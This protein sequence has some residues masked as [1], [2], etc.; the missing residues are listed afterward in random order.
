[1]KHAPLYERLRQPDFHR[2]R[3]QRS[4]CLLLDQG[5]IDICR[6][7]QPWALPEHPSWDEDPY[8]DDTWGLYYH[9]LGWLISLDYGIDH[10]ADTGKRKSCES[11]LQE[12]FF[13][14]LRYLVGT[15]DTDVHKMLWFDH[16][17]AWRASVIAYLYE[18]RF[19]HRSAPDEIELLRSAALL[20]ERKLLEF[21]ESGRWKANNHG[22]FHAEALW[23]LA[24]TFDDALDP[25]AT[26]EVAL[27]AMR[28][29][30]AEMI[31]FKE[32]VCREHSI[33][34]H[35]YD[36]WLLS[37]SV[38]YMKR[39]GVDVVPD[40]RQ[41]L[42]KM[43]EFYHR[44][45]PGQRR[46]PAIGDTSFG[47]AST[48]SMLADIGALADLTPVARYLTD[49]GERVDRPQHLSTYPETGFY[50][51]HDESGAHGPTKASLAIVLDKPYMGAH[52]HTDG[53]SF[54]IDIEGRPV[55]VDS[56]GPFA[57]GKKLRFNYFKAAEAHNV[58]IVDRK[59]TSY[60][61]NASAHASSPYGAAVRLSA[62]NLV[63]GVDWQR[64]FVDLGFG[65][66]VV[67]DAITAEATRRFDA[68]LHFAPDL[69]VVPCGEGLHALQANGF[70]ASVTQVSNRA[71]DSAVV[72]GADQSFP[73]GMVTPDLGRQQ[74]APVLSTGFRASGGWLVTMINQGAPLD[75]AV[76]QL[77]GAKLLR[78]LIATEIGN[79]SIDVDLSKKELPP[80]LISYR[81]F[82]A[83][84]RRTSRTS[85]QEA[86][87]EN[88]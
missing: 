87:P 75:I 42:T 5:V 46:L 68:L 23:D 55:V 9:T 8:G 14:Y 16:S 59:S 24:H 22:I 71:I 45:A 31:N 48:S 56:G 86:T 32:G 80:R 67:V 74:P 84:S 61:T 76:H 58:V 38:E 52:A 1:M 50:V 15:P 33:Y 65:T 83:G 12:L 26:K 53:G 28:S 6:P 62:S 85:K 39:F 30:F 3:T 21:I 7:F 11:R 43:V 36:A 13:S 4:L 17:T 20:H 25:V 40:S 29:V 37:K 78:I 66:Y 73:R 64:S 44:C 72:I 81:A 57:Y 34:Y 77:F 69:E 18:R 88:E 35:L 49:V 19:K 10:G 2:H 27:A 47:K 82:G 63:P 60:L 51:F 70:R 41:V 54:T 79:R